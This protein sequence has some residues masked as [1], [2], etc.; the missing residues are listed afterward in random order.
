M[1]FQAT[2]SLFFWG[3]GLAHFQTPPPVG[4]IPLLTPPPHQALRIRTDV[5]HISSQIYV[6]SHVSLDKISIHLVISVHLIHLF[7][8]SC[9][10]RF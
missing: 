9:A 7:Q 5:P 4:R 3:R 1:P 10:N 2:N 6:T 8:I